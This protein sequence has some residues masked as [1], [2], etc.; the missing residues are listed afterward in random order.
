LSQTLGNIGTIAPLSVQSV[1]DSDVLALADMGFWSLRVRDAS[2]NGTV[3]DMGTPINQTIQDSII[4]AGLTASAAACGIVE[5]T[6][7][8]YWCY[9]NST[10]YVLSYF[11][12][13]NIAAW[14]TYVPTGILIYNPDS[15]HYDAGGLSSNTFLTIGALYRWTKGVND[16]SM[17]CGSTTLTANGTFTATATSVTYAG[18]PLALVTNTLEGL[19]IAFTP[20]KFVVYQGQI[21]ARVSSGGVDRLCRY[22]GTDNNTYDLTK[23]VVETPWMHN[24]SPATIKDSKGLDIVFSGMWDAYGSMNYAQV[25]PT[26]FNQILSEAISTPENPTFAYS[27]QGTHVMFHFETTSQQ[28]AVLSSMMWHYNEGNE[29]T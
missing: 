9:L 14:S 7:N 29:K 26:G 15:S 4:S 21:F 28:R 5:P 20:K 23:L 22:G 19:N 27:D 3:V 11:S 24:Q 17:T 1:G 8:R 18:T 25:Y 2:N 16:T 6:T 12:A 10:I 13:A